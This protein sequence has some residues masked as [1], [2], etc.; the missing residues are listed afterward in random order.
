VGHLGVGAPGVEVE[1]IVPRDPLTLCSRV[2]QSFEEDVFVAVFPHADLYAARPSPSAS[3]LSSPFK[4]EE[5]VE[6][7]MTFARAR[8]WEVI[9]RRRK[10]SH[11]R[12]LDRSGKK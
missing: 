11:Q 1:D 8:K 7:I 2:L 10:I 3:S 4:R 5:D 9:K 6:G 12:S